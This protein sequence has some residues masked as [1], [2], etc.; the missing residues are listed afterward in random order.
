[1][2]SSLAPSPDQ[3][4]LLLS[5]QDRAIFAALQTDGRMAF[6]AVA[7]RV[8]MSEAHVRRRYEWLTESSAFVVTAVADPGVLGLKCLAW[9]G[10]VVR[11]GS[12]EEV[13][14]A[15][16]ALSGVDYVV[17]SSGRYTVMA[18]IACPDAADLDPILVELRGIDGI[19]RTETFMYLKLVRQQFQ[20]LLPEGGD[21]Q[22]AV[23]TSSVED[24]PRQ[25]D[26][27]DIAIIRELEHDGRASFRDIGRK[28]DVSE[29]TVSSRFSQLNAERVLKVIAVGNPLNLGFNSMAWLGINLNTGA[30][31]DAVT[32]GLATIPAIDYVVVPTGRYDVMAELVCR[33]PATML[34]TLIDDIGAIT[35]IAHVEPFVYLKL[36]YKST[37]G[38]WGVGRSLAAPRK[39]IR[40]NGSGP[41]ASPA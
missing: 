25:L 4:G 34:R 10:I 31:Y 39:T 9:I 33:D 11:P 2:R 5:P 8:G 24:N 21:S 7:E 23:G 26:E 19:V 32:R 35:D 16:V 40:E 20:W 41:I 36:L 13:A 37:A 14:R 12:T 27:L 3:A 17:I 22:R 18:E 29:R 6:T 30:D 38:A 15:L 1:M 28:L